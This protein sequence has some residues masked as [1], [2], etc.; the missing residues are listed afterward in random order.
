LL[1][2]RRIGSDGGIAVI[3]D[4]LLSDDESFVVSEFV[5][6][7]SVL[8]VVRTSGALPG[9]AIAQLAIATVTGLVTIHT[10]GLAHDDV[11]PRTV[12]LGPDGPR[13]VDVGLFPAG[14]SPAGAGITP[15]SG[16][17]IRSSSTLMAQ[18]SD[19]R[20]W[21]SMIAYA[22]TGRA[23][24][25]DRTDGDG[26]GDGG[27]DDAEDLLRDD[28]IQALPGSLV[29]IVRACVVADP[30]SCPTSRQV[31]EQLRSREP[32]SS[33]EAETIPVPPPERPPL[34]TPPLLALPPAQPLVAQPLA[35]PPLVA[36]PSVPLV[37]PV[38]RFA[39][40]DDPA[41]QPGS[42]LAVSPLAM[43]VTQPIR[44]RMRSRRRVSLAMAT[45]L[46]GAILGVVL[47]ASAVYA[48]VGRAQR[49][50]GPAAAPARPAD[51]AVPMAAGRSS[52]SAEYRVVQ[53]WPGGFK[54]EVTITSG[55]VAIH[56]WTVTWPP[57]GRLPTQFWNVS[58]TSGGIGTVARNASWNGSVPA[59]RST[60]F[61]FIGSAAK[62]AVADP[63]LTCTAG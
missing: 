52:C 53:R 41:G 19:L 56:G 35:I 60:T 24:S 58:L 8:D 33:P 50:A 10:A 25:S 27:R 2:A 59:G 13:L 49:S 7:P 29:G 36:P 37:P 14:P 54:A 47:G 42:P 23:P 21:A 9:E 57:G 51:V 46:V 62:D 55:D 38:T 22:A 18:K 39:I 20:A 16:L 17:P 28:A 30:A 43:P 61:G 26:D 31:L 40:D 44:T 32:P 48:F 4:A 34:V 63:A 1:R 12:V 15:G 11:H 45:A 6:G 5:P 3:L